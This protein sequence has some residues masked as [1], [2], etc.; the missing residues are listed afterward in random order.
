MKYKDIC[1]YVYMYIWASRLLACYIYSKIVFILLYDNLFSLSCKL[2]KV[3]MI[4]K[5]IDFLV[6]IWF[7]CIESVWVRII[8][9]WIRVN[10]EV[11]NFDTKS[12]LRSIFFGSVFR[13]YIYFAW[14]IHIIVYIIQKLIEIESWK[15]DP[16]LQAHLC[17]VGCSWCSRRSWWWFMSN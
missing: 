15:V 1:I 4:F 6:I 2:Y 13:V 7:Q 12:N 9:F 14:F 8:L 3:Q 10:F 16:R 5:S 11:Y 17:D